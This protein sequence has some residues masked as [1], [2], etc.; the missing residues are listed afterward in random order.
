MLLTFTCQRKKRISAMVGFVLF[1]TLLLLPLTLADDL[2]PGKTLLIETVD[3]PKPEHQ[4]DE[5]NKLPTEHISG[6]DNGNDY[7]L[8]S[9]KPYKGGKKRVCT[10]STIS[11]GFEVHNLSLTRFPT[12]IWN[13]WRS[14]Y[15][16]SDDDG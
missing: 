5:K 14:L 12:R 3:E 1:A 6:D 15:F 13:A 7:S 11:H 8:D 2:P 4:N 16:V 10:G 9:S